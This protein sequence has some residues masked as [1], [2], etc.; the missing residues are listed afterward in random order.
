MTDKLDDLKVMAQDAVEKV[1]TVGTN[2]AE[3]VKESNAGKEVLGEDGKLGKDDL[4]RLGNDFKN[5]SVGKTLLG[6]DGKLDKD[7]LTRLGGQ[8]S[9]AAKNAADTLKGFLKK[10]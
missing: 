7:D 8:V 5:S 4:E 10:D 2:I 3:T 1:K 6:E 9:G